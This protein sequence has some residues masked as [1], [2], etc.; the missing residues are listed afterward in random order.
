MISENQNEHSRLLVPGR[1][2]CGVTCAPR[3]SPFHACGGGGVSWGEE[4]ELSPHTAVH[5]QG[6]RFS[7][8][9]TLRGQA[10]WPT[11]PCPLLGSGFDS[12]SLDSALTLRLSK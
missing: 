1:P 12:Q 2:C 3:T 7:P 4:K 9:V 8:T 11:P 5:T 6:A 10:G